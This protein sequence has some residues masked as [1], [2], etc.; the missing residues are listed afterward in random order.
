MQTILPEFVA[1]PQHLH[2]LEGSRRSLWTPQ[3]DTSAWWA[4]HGGTV[5]NYYHLGGDSP[6]LGID[7]PCRETRTNHAKAVEDFLMALHA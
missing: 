1:Y 7:A 2:A 4:H 6:S 3:S 5:S